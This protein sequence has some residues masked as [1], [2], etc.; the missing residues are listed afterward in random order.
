MCGLSVQFLATNN[1]IADLI[2][3][4]Q[5]KLLNLQG[6][7]WECTVNKQSGTAVTVIEFTGHTKVAT[8]TRKAY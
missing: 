2:K 5:I 1:T 4:G 6:A 8:A 7:A 3:C